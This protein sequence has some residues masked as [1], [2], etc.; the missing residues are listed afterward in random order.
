MKIN[1][2][3]ELYKYLDSL[4]WNAKRDTSLSSVYF[5]V[6]YDN[7]TE[8]IYFMSFEDVYFPSPCELHRFP[9]KENE[10]EDYVKEM[11]YEDSFNNALEF[12]KT[13]QRGNWH[14][15]IDCPQCSPFLPE[16]L[17]NIEMISE[18][19]CLDWLLERSKW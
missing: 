8:P 11:Y 17:D 1:S 10:I 15:D 14:Y 12:E 9:F 18:N 3:Q 16:Q 2:K 7:H 4:D 19:E 13:M 6:T 5:L